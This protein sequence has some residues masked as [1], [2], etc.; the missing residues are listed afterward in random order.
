MKKLSLLLITY[1]CL[2]LSLDAQTKF[3]T[4]DNGLSSSLVNKIYQDRNGMVWIAT[5]DGLNRYDGSKITIYKHDPI[6]KNSLCHNFVSTLFEDREGR[7]FVGTYNGIQMYD[8]ETDKFSDNAIW[9]DGKP[10]RSNCKSGTQLRNGE[11]WLSGNIPCKLRIEN[12]ELIVSSLESPI[13]SGSIESIM[14]DSFGRL[15]MIISGDKVCKI[16]A[17]GHLVYYMEKEPKAGFVTLCE[18]KQG[19]VYAGSLTKGLMKY[20]EN[21]NDFIPIHDWK[22]TSLPVMTIYTDEQNKVYV[23]TDGRGMKLL[24]NEKQR[25]IDFNID[26]SGMVSERMKIHSIMK[27]KDGN[28]WI[29]IYQ[30]G[31]I[32][33]PASRNH[34]HYYGYKSAES[35]FIGSNCTTVI[36]K[37]TDG[38]LWVGTDN[39]GIYGLSDDTNQNV[40]YCSIDDKSGVPSTI[41]S[42]FEDSE[43]NL[44]IGAYF[45]GLGTLNRETGK[46]NN[47]R[48]LN[49]QQEV[50]ERV[51][52]IVEDNDKRLWI[53]TM[54]NGIF[55]YDLKRKQIKYNNDI[56][57]M[58]E[59]DWTTCLHYS[60]QNNKLYIGSYDGIGCT[61]LKTNDLQTTWSLRRQIILDIYEDKNGNLWLGTSDGLVEWDLKRDIY[62]TYT[63]A[64]GLP[65]NAI[66]G[67][68]GDK[69]EC[70]WLSTNA[71]LAQFNIQTHEVT[72]YYVTDGLQGNEFS[73]GA[74]YQDAQGNIYFGGINGITYFSPKEIVSPN[75]RWNV[76]VTDFYVRNHPVRKGSKS[77]GKEI[78]DA[79][80]YESKTFNLGHMD[81]NFSIEIS[82]TELNAPERITYSYSINDNEWTELPKGINYISFNDLT[83]G[84]YRLNI[85]AIDNTM[86][87]DI[88]TIQINIRNP[89]WYTWW[90]IT[91]YA[92]I[93][94]ALTS[95]LTLFVR[96]KVNKR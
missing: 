34:F 3:F 66:Y 86:E 16:T 28:H 71:G 76:R 15:W 30:K 73:K 51:Y 49:Q 18:D 9:K 85:K 65:S 90:A 41:M 39:D 48:I 36:H 10:F 70:L 53:A 12:G 8:P 64:H 27:D 25:L 2:S 95:I 6:D 4:T 83:P 26:L 60:A 74:S 20:D 58:A 1:L 55:C 46:F 14:E 50:V 69:Q 96:R 52:D 13:P 62:T 56:K 17:S 24:D 38:T 79:A 32:M 23:G 29:A 75:K 47:V 87:S 37:D 80:V 61:D 81:N 19:N 7:L 33:I 82:T 77:G 91:I 45:N 67:V 11:I 94:I 72:N 31:V 54:G 89:W 44:W 63:M 88:K 92:L 22:K 42:I 68:Q 93:G 43:K 21:K 40:H 84:N 57:K 78:M 59:S 35:N 5:E